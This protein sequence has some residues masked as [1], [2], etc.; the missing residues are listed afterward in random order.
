[1]RKLT[2]GVLLIAFLTVSARTF[3][4]HQGT[5]LCFLPQ[6]DSPASLVQTTHSLKD[7]LE[8]AKVKNR[9]NQLIVGYRIGW[10]A[11][12]STG[13]EKVG[14]GLP[15][16]LPSGVSPGAT[17]D[18]PAQGV[19]IDYAKEGAMAVVFFVADVRTPAQSPATESNVWKASLEKCEE[20]ALVM[21]KSQQVPRTR[22]NPD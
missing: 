14:L 9:S 6:S 18:V 11:V 10:I 15:V 1:M 8:S 12:Y 17:V 7:L 16:D 4:Q 5:G 19:S 21:S 22:S 13:K 3:A 2:S 20:Q